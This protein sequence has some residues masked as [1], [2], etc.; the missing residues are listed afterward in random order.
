[1]KLISCWTDASS[2]SYARDLQSRM[3]GVPVQGKGLLATEGVTTVPDG[4]GR[5]VLAADS[6]FYEFL[7][8]QGRVCC[9]G[10]LQQ[11]AC[12]E[13][14]MTTSGGLYR[15]RSGDRVRCEGFAGDVPLLTFVGR[16]GLVSDLV[17]EKLTEAFVEHCLES[18]PGFR[19]LVP[20]KGG[21]PHYT[22]VTERRYAVRCRTLL[23]AVESQL[24]ENP[25]YAYARSL[26]QL[27]K[28]TLT[29][30]DD[31]L[32]LYLEQVLQRQ[33]LGDIKLPALCSRDDKL[34]NRMAGIP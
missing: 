6:G 21:E 11:G 3:P 23:P 5:P 29:V 22:L 31:P 34:V 14:V 24:M 15:Y 33:R 10:E 18:I 12:C 19:M 8:D 30:K 7:D 9:A 2:R 1:M 4:E 17:G 20:V 13:V 27:G 28:L 26:G 25:Q 16:S 32:G